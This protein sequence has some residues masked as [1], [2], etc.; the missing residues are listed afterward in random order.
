MTMVNHIDPSRAESRRPKP[1]ESRSTAHAAFLAKNAEI[2]AM[3]ARLQALS[4]ADFEMNPDEIDWRHVG[5][6]G[7]YASL[8]KC[9][10]DAA[11]SEGEHAE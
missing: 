10:T 7:H 1:D 4:T 2:A 5:T 9:V 3:L 6:L 8:L 11:F